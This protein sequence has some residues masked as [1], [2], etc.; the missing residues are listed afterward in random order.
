MFTRVT[1][2]HLKV[3]TNRN[4]LS[5]TQVSP[6]LSLTLSSEKNSTSAIPSKLEIPMKRFDN[7]GFFTPR[8]VKIIP[9]YKYFHTDINTLISTTIIYNEYMLS[10]LQDRFAITK[11]TSYLQL[12]EMYTKSPIA[13]GIYLVCGCLHIRFFL[14]STVSFT[15]V[16]LCRSIMPEPAFRNEQW[17]EYL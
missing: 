9:G 14:A 5:L 2:F 15:L 11:H 1:V 7:I 8:G 3:V 16:V 17:F 4:T 12:E 6:S 10:Y 13:L